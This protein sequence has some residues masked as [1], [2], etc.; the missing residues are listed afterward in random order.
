MDASSVSEKERW[1]PE[2]LSRSESTMFL[3]DEPESEDAQSSVLFDLPATASS[4]G[5]AGPLVGLEEGLEDS[6]FC[7]LESVPVSGVILGIWSSPCVEQCSLP[8]STSG[9][10]M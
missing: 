7:C 4:S 2:A 5:S 1:S 10:V 6:C 8:T 9:E 3:F